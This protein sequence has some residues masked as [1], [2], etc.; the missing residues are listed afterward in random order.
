L[1]SRFRTERE[2]VIV[3]R[4]QAAGPQQIASRVKGLKGIYEGELVMASFQAEETQPPG[5]AV[6]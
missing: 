4:G 1:Q 5:E 6:E 3:L 2:E